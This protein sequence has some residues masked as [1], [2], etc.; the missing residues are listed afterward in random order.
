MDI[1][2]KISRLSSVL[3]SNISYMTEEETSKYKTF[4]ENELKKIKEQESK[5]KSRDI[6]IE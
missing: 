5:R 4:L 2:E 6:K 1:L 3:G